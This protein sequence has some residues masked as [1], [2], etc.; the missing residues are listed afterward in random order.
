MQSRPL[1]GDDKMCITCRE[2]SFCSSGHRL[3]YRCTFFCTHPDQKHIE[4]FCASHR[5]VSYPGFICYSGADQKPVIKTTPK[6][7]PLKGGDFD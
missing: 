4:D 6:W 3:K 5:V 2:C 1:E 7:C